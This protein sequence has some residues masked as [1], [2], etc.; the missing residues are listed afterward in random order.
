MIVSFLINFVLNFDVVMEIFLPNFTLMYKT[1]ALYWTLLYAT[2]EPCVRSHKVIN[3][4]F[5]RY[6]YGTHAQVFLGM[7][8]SQ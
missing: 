7:K 8:Y 1:C 3:Y 4:V 5:R 2:S 6:F